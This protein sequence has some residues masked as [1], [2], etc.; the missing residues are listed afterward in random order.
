M[1]NPNL[2]LEVVFS[3]QYGKL[4]SIFLPSLFSKSSEIITRCGKTKVN[5]FLGTMKIMSFLKNKNISF[6]DNYCVWI[7]D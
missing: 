7:L 5:S 2:D 6:W 3:L 4:L 1:I